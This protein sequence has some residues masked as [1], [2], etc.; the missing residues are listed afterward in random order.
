MDDGRETANIH[1]ALPL[2]SSSRSCLGWAPQKL[3]NQCRQTISQIHR[4]GD[5]LNLRR[6]KARAACGYDYRPGLQGRAHK[7]AVDAAF[8][9]QIQ[10]VCRIDFAAVIA[11]APNA[12]S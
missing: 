6:L 2:V 7:D 9:I 1:S 10:V 11:A 3:W 8:G 12:G 5:K 4:L